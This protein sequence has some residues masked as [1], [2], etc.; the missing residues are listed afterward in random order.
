MKAE[1][2]RYYFL[3]TILLAAVLLR[4]WG[5]PSL[6]LHH[7]AAHYAM[8]ALGWFDFMA[9]KVQ[10]SPIVW[11]NFIPWWANFSFSDQPPLV[12]AAEFLSFRIFGDSAAAA[13][14]PSLL[15]GIG[16]VLLLFY[17]LKR[18]GRLKLALLSSALFAVSSYAIW[19]ARLGYLEAVQTIFITAA[20]FVFCRYLD[21]REKKDFYSSAVFLG[22]SLLSKYTSVF[23]IPVMFVFLLAKKIPFYRKSEFWLGLLILLAILSP[24]IIYNA[25]VFINRGHFDAGLSSALGMKTVDFEMFSG[26][27]ISLGSSYL[28]GLVSVIGGF[29][30]N[31]SFGIFWLFVLAAIW[32]FIQIA[33]RQA[34]TI[35]QLS[36]FAA[37]AAVLMFPAI[38]TTERYYVI[39]IPFLCVIGA[40]FVLQIFSFLPN[41]IFLKSALVS[42]LILAGG[43]EVFYAINTNL[44]PAPLGKV[45]VMYSGFRFDRSG[46]GE[47]DNYLR[48]NAYGKIPKVTRI[49]E[50]SD[51]AFK[52]DFSGRDVILWDERLEWFSRTWYMNRYLFYYDIPVVT[53]TDL[54]HALS[55]NKVDLF[56]FLH[57]GG[58]T[59][60]WFVIGTGGNLNLG[61][62]SYNQ[63]M[64]EIVRLF[65]KRRVYPSKTIFDGKGQEV[66]RV[67]HLNYRASAAL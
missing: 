22:L 17:F 6:E 13:V 67:Y 15:A 44:L 41:K 31:M 3:G 42:I 39:I 5:L 59:G 12:F 27:T 51:M 23:L 38:G 56:T 53:F 24:V 47:L 8:R 19:A 54:N 66:I 21:S 9:G 10:T 1:N 46:F 20:F 30:S 45:G 49:E 14:L 28:P 37:L 55:Q 57:S 52:Q 35:V 4:F 18:Q 36:F 2:F 65:S 7:D 64:D 11:F 33:R 50:F 26:R 61:N 40:W 60:V 43:F 29:E 34:E 48:E 63:T 16:T 58:A 32:A 62:E 25:G